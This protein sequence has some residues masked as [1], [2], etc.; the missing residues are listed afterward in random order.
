MR[1]CFKC[2]DHSLK[3]IN[4]LFIFYNKQELRFNH[5]K[6]DLSFSLILLS[7]VKDCFEL[8]LIKRKWNRISFVLISVHS[9]TSVILLYFV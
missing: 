3:I 1:S 9:V 6:T 5:R 8:A 7:R 2:F 4:S